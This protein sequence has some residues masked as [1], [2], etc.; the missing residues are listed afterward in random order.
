MLILYYIDLSV[1]LLIECFYKY[2][3]IC[4]LFRQLFQQQCLQQTNIAE[5]YAVNEVLKTV[6][7]F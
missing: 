7:C 1:E 4:F 3:Y 6:K 5:L 2:D